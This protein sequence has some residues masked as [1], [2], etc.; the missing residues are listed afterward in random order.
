MIYGIGA[1]F[2]YDTTVIPIAV[3]SAGAGLF[4]SAGLIAAKSYTRAPVPGATKKDREVVYYVRD[5][6]VGFDMQYAGKLS[7]VFQRFHRQEEYEGTGVG[8]AIV[9]RIVIRH[10][11]TIG[12]EAEPDRG[13]TFFFTTGS[14]SSLLH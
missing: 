2:L 7:G 1:P 10:G 5:N 9:K 13:E 4:F 12:A 8:L 6:G 11:G 3:I 14:Q